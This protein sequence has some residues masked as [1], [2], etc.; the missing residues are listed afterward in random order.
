LAPTS[1]KVVK[2]TMISQPSDIS[3]EVTCHYEPTYS[4][5]SVIMLSTVGFPKFLIYINFYIT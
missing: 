5:I 3:A 2:Q 4:D 1:T